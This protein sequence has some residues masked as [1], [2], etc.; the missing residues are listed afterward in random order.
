MKYNLKNIMKNAWSLYRNCRMG[1]WCACT[2]PSFAECLKNAWREAKHQIVKDNLEIEAWK[3]YNYLVEKRKSIGEDDYSAKYNLET[4]INKELRRLSYDLNA[5]SVEL[6]GKWVN[7][8]NPELMAY[9]DCIIAKK[10]VLM[11]VRKTIRK[12]NPAW[13]TTL[14]PLPTGEY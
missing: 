9:Q 3:E 12:G 4:E 5:K 11:A 14:G 10:N 6:R 2:Y 13:F 8:E 7:L 1:G